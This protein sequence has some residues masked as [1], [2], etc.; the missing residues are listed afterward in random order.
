MVSEDP[1]VSAQSSTKTVTIQKVFGSVHVGDSPEYKVGSAINELLGC[2]AK[3]PRVFSVVRRRPSS[4]TVRKIKYNDI[5][6]KG[7][8]IKQYLEHSAK[9]E[10]AYK[11]I[12]SMVVSGKNIILG[13]LNDLYY[14][15]LDSLGIEY[16]ISGEIDILRVREDSDF[17]IDFII[18]RL[19]SLV[20]ESSNTPS[21]R[22]QIEHGVNVVV[23]H[24]FIECVVLEN[25]SDDS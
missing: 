1:V 15:A 12:D 17:I 22:E 7:H 14:A 19:N 23:A 21:C 9:I 10:E 2:L 6:S 8:V 18:A 25:P 3:K 11:E 4:E 20:Y 24:A 13:N 5:E 16:L